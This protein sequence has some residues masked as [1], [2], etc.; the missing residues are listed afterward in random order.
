MASSNAA[1][2]PPEDDYILAIAVTP[3][4]IWSHTG[5]VFQTSD[6]RTYIL[7]LAW[8]HRLT[9]EPLALEYGI[10]PVRLSD[11]KAKQVIAKCQLVEKRYKKGEIPY[12]LSSGITFSSAGEIVATKGATGLTCASFVIAI[13]SSVGIGLVDYS[14]WHLRPEDKIVH[15]RLV[16]MLRLYADPVHANNV[17]AQVD[18]VRIRPEEVAV[19]VS[20]LPASPSS[21]PDVEQAATDFLTALKL[22]FPKQP[23]A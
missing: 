9:F 11:P 7:H 16:A 14:T 18:S 13:F 3:T 12:G 22:R 21:L 5:I 8:H 17:A 1:R 4:D 23:Q 20:R 2:I 15:E 10:C 6:R 19:A